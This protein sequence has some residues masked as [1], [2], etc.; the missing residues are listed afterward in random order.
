MK[1]VFIGKNQ[2]GEIPGRLREQK[3]PQL[4]Q[5]G[6]ENAARAAKSVA[7][8]PHP[9]GGTLRFGDLPISSAGFFIAASEFDETTFDCLASTA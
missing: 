3:L 9:I 5:Q 4:T 1:L 8:W 7:M 6:R 2:R